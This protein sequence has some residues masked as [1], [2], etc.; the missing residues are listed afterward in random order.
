MAVYHRYILKKK[1]KKQGIPRVVNESV[2]HAQEEKIHN[3]YR[4]SQL[5]P[6]ICGEE[7]NWFSEHSVILVGRRLRL[8]QIFVSSALVLEQM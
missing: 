3:K 1:Q 2:S 4:K 5:L 7:N 6:N 8:N